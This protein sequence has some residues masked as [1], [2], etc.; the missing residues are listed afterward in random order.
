VTV[1]A[2]AGPTPLWYLARGSGLVSLLLLTASVVLGIVTTARWGNAQWPRFTVNL[3]HRNVSLLA[4]AFLLVHIA[5]MVLDGFAPIGW[6]DTVIPFVSPYRALWLGLGVLA[7]DLLVAVIVTSL[8]R[9]RVGARVWRLVHWLTYPLWALAVLH[10]LGTGTDIRTPLLLIANA[11]CVIA[12]SAAV[13]WRCTIARSSRPALRGA[14]FAATVMLPVALVAWLLAGPL[15]SGWASRAGTPS[16]LLAGTT[17]S[18]SASGASAERGVVG[19]GYR[20]DFA[21]TVTQSGRGSTLTITVNGTLDRGASGTL[22]VSLDARDDGAGSLLV[23]DGRVSVVD[24]SGRTTFDGSVSDVRDG[25]LVASGR[26]P[27]SQLTIQ[28]DTFDTRTGT[29]SGVVRATGS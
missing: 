25:V 12:V 4:C 15:A 3:I 9:N 14:V 27:A 7:F 18:D 21:G 2:I 6:M 23:R 11:A 28:F 26:S 13:W 24:T 29:A 1:V 5:T 10:G 20:A 8:L 16:E 17:S 22:A 19:P